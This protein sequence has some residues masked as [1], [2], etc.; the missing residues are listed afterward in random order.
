MWVSLVGFHLVG[1]NLITKWLVSL[2]GS[3]WSQFDHLLDP[4]GWSHLVPSV[5]EEPSET[6]EMDR[7]AGSC[8]T[9]TSKREYLTYCINPMMELDYDTGWNFWD[10]EV[11]IFR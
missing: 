6:N 2:R 1:V 10:N 3:T 7:L 8:W 11:E 5:G 9:G 4:L